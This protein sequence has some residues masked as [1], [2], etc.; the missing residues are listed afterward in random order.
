MKVRRAWTFDEI[1]FLKEN[2]GSGSTTI[3]TLV[4]ELGRTPASIKIK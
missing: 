3:E 2:Y 4:R 1:E